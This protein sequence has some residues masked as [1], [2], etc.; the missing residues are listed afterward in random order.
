VLYQLSYLAVGGKGTAGAS[1][2][3]VS[4][5]A[6]I[7]VGAAGVAVVVA[8][9]A[10]VLLLRGGDDRDHRPIGGDLLARALAYAP[11]SSEVVAVL[12]VAPGSQQGRAVRDLQRTFPAARFAADSGRSAI[13]SLGFDARDDPPKLLAGP[14]VVAGP[15]SAISRVI[16][17]VG[18]LKLDVGTLLRAGSTVAFVGR[19]PGDVDDVVDAA[20]DRRRLRP[21]ADLPGAVQQYALPNGLGRMGVRDG[22]VVLAADGPRLAAAFALRARHAG[23]TRRSFEARMGPLLR[24]P[25]LVRLVLLPRVLIGAAAANVPWVKALRSGAVAISVAS[26]GLRLRAHLATDPAGLRPEDLPL[27]PGAAPPS[28]AAGPARLS[29]GV[30]DLA[31]TIHVLDAV[32]SDLRIPL[33]SGVTNA[34]KTLDKYKG[35]LKTFGGIDVD[36]ALIDQ[37]TATTTITQ[38]AHGIA[39]RA[40]LRDGRPLRTALNRIAAVPD[41]LINLAGIGVNLAKAGDDAYEVREHSRTSLRVAVYGNTLIVTNDLGATLH[42]IAARRPVRAPA[43]GALAFRA[44]GVAVQDLIIAQLRL[45]PLARL[46]LGGFGDFQGSARAEVSGLDVDATLALAH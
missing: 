45:P 4:R 29:A 22:D 10:V 33:L 9:V 30:R 32:K 3:A 15:S 25:A 44:Q 42:A 1:L 40:E 36:Q 46:V 37:L 34:L 8:V 20:A 19:S 5:R 21:L 14:L 18:S 7:G 12:D 39:L 31:Q 6:R 41:F 27:A 2:A 35:P 26:P 17:G 11:A 13:A 24:T 43:A 23:T 28:P 38:E 16:A